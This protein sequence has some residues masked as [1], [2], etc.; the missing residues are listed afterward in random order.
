[1]KNISTMLFVFTMFIVLTAASCKKE[2]PGS[3]L[4]TVNG[5]TFGCR[6]NGTPF[7]ADKWDHVN[8]IPPVRIR[9]RYSPVLQTNT[10]Q[11][12]AEKENRLIELWI[13]SP[14]TVGTKNLNFSTLPHPTIV[15]PLDY[16]LYQIFYP[17]KEFITN[18]SIGGHV[19][20]IVADTVNQRVEG[21]FEFTGTDRITGEKVIIT[22]G[23]FKNF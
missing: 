9:F 18:N 13:N 2:K 20:I 12:L 21:T 19:N 6:V 8:N 17:S 10:L 14:V 4:V 15:N 5:Q 1:M 22:N 3:E 7:I 16:G 23:Y 11:V